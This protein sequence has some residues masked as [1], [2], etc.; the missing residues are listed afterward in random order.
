[1]YRL[2]LLSGIAVALVFILG[3]FAQKKFNLSGTGFLIVHIL[4]YLVAVFPAINR[5]CNDLKH[6]VVLKS[7]VAG[8]DIGSIAALLACGLQLVIL[9]PIEAR[10]VPYIGIQCVMITI[11]MLIFGIFF[12]G[13]LGL[14]YSLRQLKHREAKEGE[15]ESGQ[16]MFGSRRITSYIPVAL[17]LLIILSGIIIGGS[18]DKSIQEDSIQELRKLQPE[19]G[20]QAPDVQMKTLDGQLWR[21]ADKRGKVVLIDFWATWHQPC[22]KA[23]PMIQR[24]HQAYGDNKDFVMV[25][26]SLDR[27]QSAL[28]KFIE[29]HDMNWDILYEE[30]LFKENEFAKKFGVISIPSIWIIDKNGKIAAK[31]IYEEKQLTQKISEILE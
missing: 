30:K 15:N 14:F 2:R 22:V 9:F 13:I 29:T 24:I 23:L 31:D 12:S 27:D 11:M 17:S 20:G 7:M 26:V 28:E 5:S 16:S 6:R 1:M 18:S 10:D 4:L 21:L 8:V 25:T 3:D 19:I